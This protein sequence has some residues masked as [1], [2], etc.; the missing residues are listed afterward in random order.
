GFAPIEEPQVVIV[1][2]AERAAP[3]RPVGPPIAR[4]GL[5]AIS[6]EKPARGSRARG[7]RRAPAPPLA[8]PRCRARG[9]R[10]RDG[11]DRA[12]GRPA[13]VPAIRL[14][15]LRPR[16]LADHRGARDGLDPRAAPGGAPVDR[17]RDR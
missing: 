10:A 13:P 12:A 9:A 5:P 4:G 11:P 3:G 15:A 7:A 17:P 1:V 8:C 16:G 2:F 6:L 14:A